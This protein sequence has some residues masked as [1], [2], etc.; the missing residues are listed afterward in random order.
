M[1]FPEQFRM[2]VFGMP[3]TYAGDQFGCFLV[4]AHHACGRPLKVMVDNGSVS[5]WEHVSV[6]LQGHPSKTPSWQEMSLV[7]DLFW[8]DHEA[9][10]QFHPAKADYVNN[11]AGCLHLWRPVDG[12]FPMP[13]KT[14]V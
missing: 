13:P 8:E 5:G 1:K 11:H 9:V 12:K 2:W 10:L 3:E 6:S 14:C 4:P 7:K